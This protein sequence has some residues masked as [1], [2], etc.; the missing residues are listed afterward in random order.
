MQDNNSVCTTVTE[1][2]KNNSSAA[3]SCWKDKDVGVGLNGIH[4]REVELLFVREG[5]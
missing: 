4:S 1:C 5:I 2:V 3:F